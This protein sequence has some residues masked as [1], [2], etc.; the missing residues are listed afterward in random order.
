MPFW[1][2]HGPPREALVSYQTQWGTI[3]IVPPAED[4]R[5]NCK[6]KHHQRDILIENS[7]ISGHLQSHTW[8]HYLEKFPLL[9]ETAPP[10]PLQVHL[11]LPDTQTNT[12]QNEDTGSQWTLCHFS[13]L[14]QSQARHGQRR[15]GCAECPQQGAGNEDGRGLCDWLDI[16][17]GHPLNSVQTGYW[18]Y[19][20]VLLPT[21]APIFSLDPIQEMILLSKI[22]VLNLFYPGNRNCTIWEED[23]GLKW[24][25]EEHHS[26]KKQFLKY[27]VSKYKFPT[28]NSDV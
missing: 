14:E 7:L 23:P 26:T 13:S 11:S 17:C 9:S 10:P 27:Q 24:E 21:G 25:I 19:T 20:F 5:D 16:E 15:W 18:I 1:R 3:Q 6:L 12:F 4:F 8:F 22:K 28:T 2:G